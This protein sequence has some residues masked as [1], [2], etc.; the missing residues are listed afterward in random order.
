MNKLC[1]TTPVTYIEKQTP[2]PERPFK[3]EWDTGAEDAWRD[4]PDILDCSWGRNVLSKFPEFDELNQDLMRSLVSDETAILSGAGC[5]KSH[6]AITA[7][8]EMFGK[9]GVLVVCPYNSQAQ[10][11]RNKFGVMAI[12]YHNFMGESIDGSSN[13]APFNMEK[14]GKKGLVIDEIMLL[15]HDDLKNIWKW[16]GTS[17]TLD[18]VMVATGDQRQLEA[19][20]DIINNERKMEYVQKL[21]PQRTIR[22]NINKRLES[23]KDRELMAALEVD[24][25]NCA[26]AFRGR[27]PSGLSG[28]TKADVRKLI[29]KHFPKQIISKN[30]LEEKGIKSAVTY[31]N[32]SSSVLNDTIHSFTNYGDSAMCEIITVVA[33]DDKGIPEVTRKYYK[34]MQLTC[35]GTI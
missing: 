12:T 28:A 22:L 23:D 13:R 6:I 24:M 21:F 10:Q 3:P 15:K 7:L 1:P 29:R 34:G 20:D 31:Y 25:W 33:D 18:M 32:A 8:I 9:D 26:T 35:K 14:Y 17:K 19:I 11:V 16:K 4:G 2:Q 27:A 30:Q 5:G